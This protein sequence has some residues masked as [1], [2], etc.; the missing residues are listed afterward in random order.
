M[1]VQVYVVYVYSM[2]THKNILNTVESPDQMN[3][4]MFKSGTY[5]CALHIQWNSAFTLDYEKVWAAENKLIEIWAAIT[6]T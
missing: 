4:R 1:Q 2:F 3:V 6:I 5:I